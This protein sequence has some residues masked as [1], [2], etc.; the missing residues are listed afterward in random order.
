MYKPNIPVTKTRLRLSIAVL[1]LKT[2]AAPTSIVP[3]AVA[4]E[5]EP[6]GAGPLRCW[7][8]FADSIP[9]RTWGLLDFTWTVQDP[10]DFCT[11]FDMFTKLLEDAYGY[12]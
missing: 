3:P 5:D 1:C 2:D 12:E 8:P 10:C 4:R 11:L 6:A 9:G 7:I